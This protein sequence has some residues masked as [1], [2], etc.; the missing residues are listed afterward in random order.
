VP[1]TSAPPRERGMGMIV[2]L[3]SLSNNIINRHPRIPSLSLGPRERYTLHP[4]S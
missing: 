4:D 1:D 2:L 3:R